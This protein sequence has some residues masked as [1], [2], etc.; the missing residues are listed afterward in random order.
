LRSPATAP[1]LVD[2]PVLPG[3]P[4]SRQRRTVEHRG[5]V[6]GQ[7]MMGGVNGSL[8]LHLR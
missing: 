4:Q 2:Q 3:T 1:E 5:Q 8:N 6:S 7:Q